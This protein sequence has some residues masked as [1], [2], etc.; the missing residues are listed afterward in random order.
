MKSPFLFL[1]TLAIALL[2]LAGCG[3]DT[4]GS[5]RSIKAAASSGIDGKYYNS[6]EEFDDGTYSPES[7]DILENGV[8]R[9]HTVHNGATTTEENFFT[10]TVNADKLSLSAPSQEKED[11]DCNGLWVTYNLKEETETIQNA[12]YVRREQELEISIEGVGKV[13]YVEAD[14]EDVDRIL[15][16]PKC[17]RK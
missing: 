2:T 8:A 16:L 12:T 15:A 7:L 11:Y 1:T 14:Q 10:Y 17:T 13:I 6:R 5:G 9:R 3:Q 4:S